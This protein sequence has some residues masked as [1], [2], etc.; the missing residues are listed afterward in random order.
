M[1]R[2]AQLPPPA[3]G[4]VL[5]V[6]HVVKDPLHECAVFVEGDQDVPLMVIAIC[7]VVSPESV[8]IRRI[9]YP[10][11]PR[12]K[13][14]RL[15]GAGLTPNVSWGLNAGRSAWHG[16]PRKGMIANR[17]KRSTC[18]KVRPGI[19]GGTRDNDTWR[20]LTLAQVSME[21]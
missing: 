8:S 21:T 6:A 19:L 15:G 16:D 17:G 10:V 20:P 13:W 3:G 5:D 4:S 2:L 14:R 7:A 18:R 1:L 12:P 9:V 11:Q